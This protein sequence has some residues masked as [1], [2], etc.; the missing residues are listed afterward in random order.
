MS[1]Q[2][3]LTW[4][5][6]ALPFGAQDPVQGLCIRREQGHD[7]RS[8]ITESRVQILQGPHQVQTAFPALLQ[9][10]LM[11]TLPDSTVLLLHLLA[12][13]A[14]L[15]FHHLPLLQEDPD[16]QVSPG[17]TGR[18][19]G[20]REGTGEYTRGRAHVHVTVCFNPS[21]LNQYNTRRHP[22]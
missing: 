2:E 13:V 5:M 15:L 20:D 10:H 3:R 21:N 1:M 18:N 14:D 12:W 4:D 8:L 11:E 6:A 9:A 16:F 17:A 22:Q 19:Y 7:P